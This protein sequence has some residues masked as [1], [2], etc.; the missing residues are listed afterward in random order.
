MATEWAFER[1]REAFERVAKDEA[2]RLSIVQGTV[3]KSA[4]SCGVSL[5]Q[6]EDKEVLRCHICARIAPAFPWKTTC[7]EFQLGRSTAAGGAQSVEKN[8]V[9]DR[10]T[11]WWW[12]KQVSVPG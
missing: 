4:D 7:G 3:L 10:P 1:T 6:Q 12:C 11:G 5:R 2:G 9:G 8:M